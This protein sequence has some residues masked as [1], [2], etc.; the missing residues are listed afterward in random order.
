VANI[1]N[2]SSAIQQLASAT[3]VAE[4]QAIMGI[5]PA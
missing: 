2:D 5:T 4:V 3:S 1:F